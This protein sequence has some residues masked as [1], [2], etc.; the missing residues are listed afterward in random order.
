VNVDEVTV[1]IDPL[2]AT[3]EY[4]EDL[5]EYV[6]TMVCVAYKGMY[7]HPSLSACFICFIPIVLI[8]S[9]N[10]CEQ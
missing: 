9:A 1:W 4:T 8:W 2:D 3:K 10:M 6:T 5:L 7:S